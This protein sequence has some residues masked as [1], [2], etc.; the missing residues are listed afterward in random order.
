MNLK[1][2]KKTKEKIFM[3]KKLF[4]NVFDIIELYGVKKSSAYRL[5]QEL[6]EELSNQGFYTQR[7]VVNAEYFRKRVYA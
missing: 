5:I 4:Y 6:N 7:G 3:E 1:I 2:Q